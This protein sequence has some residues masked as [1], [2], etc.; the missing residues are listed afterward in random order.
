MLLI[1]RP[2]DLLK[3]SLRK[4]TTYLLKKKTNKIY[5][6]HRIFKKKMEAFNVAEMSLKVC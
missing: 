5:F 4:F 3:H 1:S 6:L 2:K